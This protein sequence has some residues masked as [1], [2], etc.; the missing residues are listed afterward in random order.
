MKVY[1]VCNLEIPGSKKLSLGNFAS[2]EEKGQ[3]ATDINRN[4]TNLLST[5]FNLGCYQEEAEN[6]NE[7][8]NVQMPNERVNCNRCGGSFKH[9]ESL[10]TH[11]KYRCLGGESASDNPKDVEE[12]YSTESER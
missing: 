6:A 12:L 8:L 4:S 9:K 11:K 2:V 3:V 10:K 1:L 5:G 7:S